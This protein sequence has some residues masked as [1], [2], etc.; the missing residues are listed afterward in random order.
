MHQVALPEYLDQ[1]FELDN[2]KRGEYMS[3]TTLIIIIL[4]ILLLGGGGW[5]GRGRWY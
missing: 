5:Y 4:V 2:I 3:T 1:T